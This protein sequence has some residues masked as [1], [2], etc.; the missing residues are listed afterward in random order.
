MAQTEAITGPNIN[1]VAGSKFFRSI[2]S[3]V[4]SGTLGANTADVGIKDISVSQTIPI[5]YM[6]QAFGVTE[7][8]AVTGTINFDVEYTEQAIYDTQPSTLTWFNHAT[9]VNKTASIDGVT[10]SPIRALRLAINSLTAGA[11]ISLTILQGV[12]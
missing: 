6:Q 12:A 3:V 5:N 9:I 11:T 4:V 7:M 10:S 2:S 1:T 8:V